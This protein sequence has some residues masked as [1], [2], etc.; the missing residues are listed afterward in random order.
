M[1]HST[2]TP[3]NSE[4]K[5]VTKKWGYTSKLNQKIQDILYQKH[6]VKNISAVRNFNDYIRFSRELEDTI[7]TFFESDSIFIWK[8]D[9]FKRAFRQSSLNVFNGEEKYKKEL[10]QLLY[11]KN[12]IYRELLLFAIEWGKLD[13]V[14]T[15][16]DKETLVAVIQ[17]GIMHLM[18]KI[19]MW[20][21]KNIPKTIE[22]IHSPTPWIRAFWWIK[23]KCCSSVYRSSCWHR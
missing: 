19:Y 16:D 12:I 14:L 23:N 3:P 1:T 21:R 9:S 6:L 7:N 4:K 13:K 8:E 17:S 11:T 10:L 15:H 2:N 20:F 18:D 5:T 22:K